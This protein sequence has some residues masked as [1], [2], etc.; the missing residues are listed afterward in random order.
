M[1]YTKKNEEDDISIGKVSKLLLLLILLN[2]FRTGGTLNKELNLSLMY[3]VIIGVLETCVLL[4]VNAGK[5]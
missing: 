5:K 4:T 3:T 2:C 1:K